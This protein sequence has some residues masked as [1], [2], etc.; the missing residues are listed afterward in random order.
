MPHALLQVEVVI[1]G[2]LKSIF[3]LKCQ[4]AVVSGST[5]LIAFKTKGKALTQVDNEALN[6]HPNPVMFFVVLQDI[7]TD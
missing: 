6:K 1:R 2:F 3:N 5:I 7:G 4:G